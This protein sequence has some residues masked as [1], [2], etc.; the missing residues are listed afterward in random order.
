ME[1]FSFNG[2]DSGINLM[3]FPS[4]TIRNLVALILALISAGRVILP[5]ELKVT[6][7]IFPRKE[8]DDPKLYKICPLLIVS[9]AYPMH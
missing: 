1:P 4:K 3:E 7:L 5:L 9:R 8:Y 2:S 6:M